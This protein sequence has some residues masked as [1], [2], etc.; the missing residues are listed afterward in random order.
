MVRTLPSNAGGVGSAPGQ[1]AKIRHASQPKKKQN[2][3]WKQYCDKFNKNFKDG[4]HQKNILK[5]CK[6]TKMKGME[7]DISQK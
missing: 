5:R 7:K 6:D 4:P 3:K 2:I 1:G